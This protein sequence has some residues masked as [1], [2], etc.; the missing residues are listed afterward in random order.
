MHRIRCAEIWGGIRDEDQDVCSAG[1][2]ASLFSSACAGGRGGDVYYL[3]VCG[4]D[5]LT[6]V[7]VAD[8]AGHGPA[9]ADVSQWLYDALAE[10]MSDP[11]GSAVLADLNRLASQRGIRALT[12]AAVVGFYTRDSN[13]YVAYAGH[14][15]LLVHRRAKGGWRAAEID[16]ASAR[17][18]NAPLGVLPEARFDQRSEPLAAGDRLFLY[19]DGLLE[20]P[21]AS[22]EPFGEQRLRAVLDEQA[23]APLAELKGAVLDAVRAHAGDPLRHDDVTLMAMAV[24]ASDGESAGA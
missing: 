6:R 12:T 20:A 3:S 7:A 4:Q 8:V 13:L 14:A 22:G 1:I 10:R 18:A 24:R 2:E 17:H 9:V 11:D 19:T 16:E 21:A 5:M 15:P 23:R